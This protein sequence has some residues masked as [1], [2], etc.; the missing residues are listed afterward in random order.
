MCCVCIQCDSFD[1]IHGAFWYKKVCYALFIE[2]SVQTADVLWIY[3][4]MDSKCGWNEQSFTT[5]FCTYT[6]SKNNSEDRNII[7]YERAFQHVE[8]SNDFIRNELNSIFRILCFSFRKRQKTVHSDRSPANSPRY[9]G[10]NERYT[11]V[12]N[13]YFMP[14]E[15][16]VL[17]RF[18]R[19]ALLEL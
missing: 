19:L 14:M 11:S 16:Y 1:C 5:Q 6:L 3:Q 2:R 13:Y 9:D 15:L 10:H 17:F 8:L 18:K 12:R 7:A 4:F